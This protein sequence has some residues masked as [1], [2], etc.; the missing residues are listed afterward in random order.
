MAEEMLI[1]AGRDGREIGSLLNVGLDIDLN[2][3]RDFE[4]SVQDRKSVV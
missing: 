4:V 3:T 2:G 1:L